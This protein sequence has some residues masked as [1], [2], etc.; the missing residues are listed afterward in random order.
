MIF[1]NMVAGL[2]KPGKEILD[3][4]SPKQAHG[5]HMAI[6]VAGEAGELLD[7]IKKSCIYQKPLDFENVI[8]ELGD[9]EFYLEGLRQSLGIDRQQTLDANMVKL[10]KRYENHKYTNEQ[11]QNR[12]DK[13]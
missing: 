6:G 2:A 5:M 10:G 8:E 7:A 12:A 13:K 11:A 4:M 1:E 9:I 3:D